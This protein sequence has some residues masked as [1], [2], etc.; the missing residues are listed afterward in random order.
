MSKVELSESS[1]AALVFARIVN[2]ELSAGRS[3]Q[4]DRYP[5]RDAK[6]EESS[7]REGAGAETSGW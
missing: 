6:I 3:E 5:D 2:D 4:N 7:T 1:S